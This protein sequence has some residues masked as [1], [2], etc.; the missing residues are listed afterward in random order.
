M[1]MKSRLIILGMAMMAFSVQAQINVPGGGDLKKAEQDLNKEVNKASSQANIGNLVAQLAG[2]LADNSLTANFKKDKTA[3]INK[4]GTISDPAG[5]SSALQ[6]L[7][8]GL[9]PAAM[10]AG[11]GA[12]KDKWVK[13]AK[14][15][16]TL[17][18]VAGLAGE[19]ES[20]IKP[21]S[22]KG[23]WAKARP[24]WQAALSTLSK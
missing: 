10:D 12:V 13:D 17:K 1:H 20:H 23:D 4:A 14:T 16:S 2:G 9:L 18:S 19:L 11:W 7:Q 22:F 24:A 8:G 21:T 15:A 5:G 6:D 3:F